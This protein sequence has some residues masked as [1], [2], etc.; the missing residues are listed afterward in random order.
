MNIQ[1]NKVGYIVTL[2]GKIPLKWTYVY[3]LT[4]FCL[5]EYCF[6]QKYGSAKH[7]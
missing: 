3:S 7:K 5:L 4:Q 2:I 1:E 6:E